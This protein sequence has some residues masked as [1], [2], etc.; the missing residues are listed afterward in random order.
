MSVLQTISQKRNTFTSFLSRQ[1]Y[2]VI[3]TMDVQCLRLLLQQACL[4]ACAYAAH[5]GSTIIA[6]SSHFFQGQVQ[7]KQGVFNYASDPF[8]RLRLSILGVLGTLL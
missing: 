7:T 6:L 1:I 2:T 8:N 5:I 4:N 3:A